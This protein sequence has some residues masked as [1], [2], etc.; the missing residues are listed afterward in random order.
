METI[1]QMK[2]EHLG[3]DVSM[4]QA[5]IEKTSFI[6]EG[7]PIDLTE[8]RKILFPNLLQYTL[9]LKLVLM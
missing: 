3:D 8:E 9:A 7:C 2:T 5:F 4:E 6:H 1:V